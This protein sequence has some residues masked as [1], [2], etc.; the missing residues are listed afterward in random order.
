MTLTLFA[1]LAA[2][3][4]V[5]LYAF[6]FWLRRRGSQEQERGPLT[7]LQPSA[8]EAPVEA[9]SVSAP[10]R[11]TPAASLPEPASDEEDA[12]R[13]I[14]TDFYDEVVHLLEAELAST[15]QRSDLRF[16]LL[17]MYAATHRKSEFLALARRHRS[18]Q[19]DSKDPY[20]PRIAEAGRQ[21][22]PEEMLFGA[23]TSTDEPEPVREQPRQ[24]RRYYDAVDAGLLAA[25]ETELH[26]A[27]QELRQA[28]S[29]WKTL[30]ALHGEFVGARAPMVYVEK[31]STF[32]GGAQIYVRHEPGRAASDASVLGAVGQVLL[33]QSLGRRQII[34]A[35]AGEGH[36]VAA[37]RAARQ[38]GLS[39]RVVVTRS[40]HLL[41]AEELQ[42]VDALGAEL[43]V[44]PDVA[45]QRMESQRAALA[46]AL[47]ARSHALYLSPIEAGPFPY[48]MIVQELQGLAG[49]DL[50]TQVVSLAGRAPDGVIVSTADGMGAIGVL[51]AFLGAKGP[52]LYCVEAGTGGGAHRLAREHAWLR[53]SGRVRYSSVPEEVARFAA[54][55][56]MP[57][58][59]GEL[60]RA[61]GE[62]LVETFTLARQFSPDEIV[63]VVIPAEAA[64][65]DAGS[66]P[67]QAA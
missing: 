6:L 29:F 41:R 50:K 15:P 54:R 36:A 57:D 24:F 27:F 25:L 55:H 9:F 14:G 59:I 48:P 18:E 60:G 28:A 34:V 67:P 56:C 42:A 33:A 40:E 19:G 51:Q 58:G 53:A 63:A 45:G 20:W 38:L 3:V 13:E 12:A 17:E 31:L 30:R 49:R 64:P 10:T 65:A 5:G 44:V 1:A 43:V 4:L 46:L 2:A 62:V 35:P 23:S 32:V 61:G 52:K 39:A 8:T 22:L 7:D 37:A 47:E 66:T 21:L 26:A 16:K 11:A